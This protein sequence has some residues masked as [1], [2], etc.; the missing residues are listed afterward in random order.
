MNTPQYKI[1]D[2]VKINRNIELRNKLAPKGSIFT[3]EEANPKVDFI[4]TKGDRYILF[5]NEI[6]LYNDKIVSIGDNF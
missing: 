1:G 5:L 3:V 6:E 4:I 2:K